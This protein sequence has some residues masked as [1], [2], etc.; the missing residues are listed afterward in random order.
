M[1]AFID[2]NILLYAAGHDAGEH[3]KRMVARDIIGG[4]AI[5]LSVQVFNEFF[6]QATRT[7]R[8]PQLLAEEASQ[9]LDGL[10]R[11]PVQDLTLS[12]FDDGLAIMRRYKCSFWDSLII[13]AAKAQRCETLFS[14]DMQDGLHV[15]GLTIRN[16][17]A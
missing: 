12:V 8:G 2:T 7:H 6:W 17:F 13:A 14:E 11:Y 16:P 4:R 15:D 5:A 10:R 9:F 1:T 3:A